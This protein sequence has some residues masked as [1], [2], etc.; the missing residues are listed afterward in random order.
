MLVAKAQGIYHVTS[1]LS[2]L[3]RLQQ[4]GAGEEMAGAINSKGTLI[5]QKT[6]V[7]SGLGPAKI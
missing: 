3:G 7:T 5:S 4:A 6:C 1:P 2:L